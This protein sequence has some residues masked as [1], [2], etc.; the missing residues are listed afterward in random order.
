MQMHL[1]AEGGHC[2]PDH[3]AA[4]ALSPKHHHCERRHHLPHDGLLVRH[5]AS[6]IWSYPQ[7]SICNP[8]L[9]LSHVCNGLL[10]CLLELLLV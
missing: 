7:P 1:H 6:P 10:Q 5:H 4:G 8:P 2:R 9:P 3:G